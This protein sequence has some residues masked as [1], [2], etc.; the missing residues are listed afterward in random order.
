MMLGGVGN[1]VGAASGAFLVTVIDRG[2]RTLRGWLATLN[3]PIEMLYVRWIIVGVLMLI[4]LMYRPNGLVPEG[5]IRTPAYR[6]FDTA[7]LRWSR[8]R[9]Y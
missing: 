2:T 4:V 5:P 6:L 9:K 3:I 8:W 1:H 7:N